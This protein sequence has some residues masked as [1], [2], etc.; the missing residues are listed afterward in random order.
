[1]V[2]FWQATVPLYT[3]GLPSASSPSKQSCRFCQDVEMSVK[4]SIL[5]LCLISNWQFHVLVAWSRVRPLLCSIVSEGN[6]IWGVEKICQKS[7]GKKLTNILIFSFDK[8]LAVDNPTPPSN[9][10]S[11]RVAKKGEILGGRILPPIFILVLAWKIFKFA[12]NLELKY[13]S[14]VLPAL[15]MVPVSMK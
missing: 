9:G 2:T 4:K 1:M 12:R 15:T 13:I 10:F 11:L 5:S 8:N 6:N 14:L 7:A 3:V